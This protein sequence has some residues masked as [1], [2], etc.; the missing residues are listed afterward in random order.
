GFVTI[1]TPAY[2]VPRSATVIAAPISLI[3]M[4]GVRYLTRASNERSMKPSEDAEPALIVGAGHAGEMIV[5]TM[6]TD[7]NSLLRPVGL[8]DDDLGKK[9]LQLHGVPVLGRTDEI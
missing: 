5:R 1:L 7:P 8:L 3:L 2:G 4:F 6:V 9:R